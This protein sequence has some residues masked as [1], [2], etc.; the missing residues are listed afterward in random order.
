MYTIWPKD[1]KLN[2][3][4]ESVVLLVDKFDAIE[5]RVIEGPIHIPRVQPLF[6]DVSKGWVGL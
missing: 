2:K 1:R 6:T 4:F 5:G 3:T